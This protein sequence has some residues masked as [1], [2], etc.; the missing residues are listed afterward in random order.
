[1]L[2]PVLPF[3][4]S[5]HIDT[6]L[7]SASS[8]D[9]RQQL[10]LRM[11]AALPRSGSTLFIRTFRELQTCAVTSRLVFMGHRTPN[12]PFQP[13]YSIFQDPISYVVYQQAL[14]GGYSTLIWKEELGHEKWKGEC[15]YPLILDPVGYEMARPA[16]LFR[17]PVRV[18]DSWK[19]L[20]WTD[21]QSLVACYKNLYNMWSSNNHTVAIIYEELIQNPR[22]ILRQLCL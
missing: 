1:M 9:I 11:L 22:Q 21:F 6:T 7:R 20:G 13:D 12:G 8:E 18:F 4:P 2:K 14:G 10:Q 17:D 19:A 3:N 16:F 15:D 5:A